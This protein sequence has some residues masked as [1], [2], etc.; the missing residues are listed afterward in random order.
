M[1]IG[2][3]D[4]AVSAEESIA[5]FAGNPRVP[6]ETRLLQLVPGGTHDGAG[7]SADEFRYLAERIVAAA[8]FAGVKGWS[9]LDSSW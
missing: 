8:E 6:A 2:T 4:E 1:S 5:W 3:A 7:H 9:G